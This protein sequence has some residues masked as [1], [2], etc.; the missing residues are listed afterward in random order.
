MSKANPS[1]KHSNDIMK[2]AH[3]LLCLSARIVV[4][5]LVFLSSC[6]S[7]CLL[8]KVSYDLYTDKKEYQIF[9]IYKEILSG[10][11]AKSYTRKGFLIYK[12]MRKY[13]PIYEEAVIVITYMTL[14]QLHSEF[15]YI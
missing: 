1:A 14:Q 8:S 7:V 13:F 4:I 11:V 15:P 3:N 12:E 10:A 2:N 6:L 5:L 9:L